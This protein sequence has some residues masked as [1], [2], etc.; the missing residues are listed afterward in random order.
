MRPYVLS[1]RQGCLAICSSSM[2]QLFPYKTSCFKK[3]N[4]ITKWM[5]QSTHMKIY[6]SIFG[7][8]TLLLQINLCDVSEAVRTKA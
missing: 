1:H 8:F 2:L 7:I 3:Q 6:G 5:S 4:A